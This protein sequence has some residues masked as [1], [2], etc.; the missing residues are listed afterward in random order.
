MRWVAYRSK[1]EY[2]LHLLNVD[3]AGQVIRLCSR[4]RA[5]PR[6]GP[7]T[8]RPII[9]LREAAARFRAESNRCNT[10]GESLIRAL[11]AG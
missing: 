2:A 8:A 5:L 9:S 1:P 10:C 6:V 11:K 4:V 7:G 3:E